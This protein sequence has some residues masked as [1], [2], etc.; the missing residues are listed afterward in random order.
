MSTERTHVTELHLLS[1]LR[2]TLNAASGILASWIF[3][4]K[5]AVSSSSSSSASSSRLN[6]RKTPPLRTDGT[7]TDAER[8]TGIYIQTWLKRQMHMC[9]TL[10]SLLGLDFLVFFSSFSPSI[11]LLNKGRAFLNRSSKVSASR[12]FTA[13]VEIQRHSFKINSPQGKS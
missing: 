8:S 6:C 12:S 9:V 4:S 2:Q 3:F 1:S 11:C 7:W 10:F 5:T 13:H